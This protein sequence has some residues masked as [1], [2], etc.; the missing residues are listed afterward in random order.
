VRSGRAIR[1]FELTNAGKAT[2][3]I[4][5]A[6]AWALLAVAMPGVAQGRP[7]SRA[8]LCVTLGAVAALPDGRMSVTV[9]K[10]RAFVLPPTTQAAEVRFTYN[11]PSVGSAPLGSGQLRRQFGLKL[12]AQDSCNLIYV[13]WRI[14]P[15]Q[16]LVVSIKRNPGKHTHAQCGTRGYRNL[17]P[18]RMTAIPALRPGGSHRLH[19]ELQDRTLRVLVDGAEAW[20]GNLGA[21]SRSFDG[22]VGLRSDNVNVSFEMEATETAAGGHA[23]PAGPVDED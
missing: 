9:P 21:Q 16:Q 15:R 23:C 19:A 11:G 2:R 22:P 12:R 10:M 6:L 8:D 18:D 1:R 20:V 4:L 5:R 17:K 7:I 14:A 3:R 13:M